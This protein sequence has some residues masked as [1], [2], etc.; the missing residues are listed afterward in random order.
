[1]KMLLRVIGL[2]T[3]SALFGCSTADDITCVNV[4]ELSDTKLGELIGKE[5]N[6]ILYDPDHFHRRTGEPEDYD[7]VDLKNLDNE[8]EGIEDNKS[9]Y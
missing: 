3:F 1:M 6:K 8:E 5:I 2:L 9:E 7:I 4:A